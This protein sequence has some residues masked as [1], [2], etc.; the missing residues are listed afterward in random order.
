MMMVIRVAVVVVHD[1]PHPACRGRLQRGNV[2]G[3]LQLEG[4]CAAAVYPVPPTNHLTYDV[5][6]VCNGRAVDVHVPLAAEGD[7]L[8]GASVVLL[9][10]R[11]G[12]GGVMTIY[13]AVLLEQRCVT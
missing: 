9:F 2:R 3:S 10:E 13:N 4:R 12:P 8:S 5:D 11:F 1:T 7:C 6:V